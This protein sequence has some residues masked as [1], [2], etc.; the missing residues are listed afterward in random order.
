M[1]GCA[2]MLSCDEDEEGL[3]G[4]ADRARG[5]KGLDEACGERLRPACN[6][7]EGA[8]GLSWEL[9]DVTFF[10]S[11]DING[12]GGASLGAEINARAS[13]SSIFCFNPAPEEGG[14]PES[15]RR[16]S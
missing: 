15:G 7:V 8:R 5:D 12:S 16:V 1:A 3:G 9:L 2:V 6:A 11:G 13:S 14:L 4:H 10:S